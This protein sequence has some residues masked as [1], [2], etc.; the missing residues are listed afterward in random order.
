MTKKKR[1]KSIK[2]GMPPG[3]MVYVGDKKETA[4]RIEV[5][6]YNEQNYESRPLKKME[7]ILGYKKNQP[8]AG[9]RSLGFMIL[10]L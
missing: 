5:I 10:I 7:E 3:T 1:R 8:S 6:D 4:V 9:L 2:T